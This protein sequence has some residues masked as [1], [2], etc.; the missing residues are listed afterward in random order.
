MLDA[1]IR[2]FY[3]D[4]VVKLQMAIR[5]YL[6]SRRIRRRR[7]KNMMNKTRTMALIQAQWRGKTARRTVQKLKLQ[8]AKEKV[9]E[10]DR[11]M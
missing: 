8:K 1:K 10:R 2:A 3:H 11:Q 5:R 6:L 7:M 4:S 9:R